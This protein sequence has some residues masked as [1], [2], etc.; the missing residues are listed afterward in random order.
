M[1]ELASCGTLRE[2]PEGIEVYFDDQL[3]MFQP[4]IFRGLPNL[5]FRYCLVG[6]YSKSCPSNPR[7]K[8]K[9]KSEKEEGLAKTGSW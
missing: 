4:V 8:A 5:C 1:I 9:L 7:G 2:V 3:S 6:H